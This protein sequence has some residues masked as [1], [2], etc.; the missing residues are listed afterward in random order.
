[1]LGGHLYN[2]SSNQQDDGRAAFGK[3]H[4]RVDFRGVEM[5]GLHLENGKLTSLTIYELSVCWFQQVSF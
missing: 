2:R 1:M 5:L 4:F 3:Q